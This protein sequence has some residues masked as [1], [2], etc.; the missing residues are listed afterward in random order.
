MF[1]VYF[2]MPL[3]IKEGVFSFPTV[4]LEEGASTI[5]TAILEEDASPTKDLELVG[6]VVL[7]SDVGFSTLLRKTKEKMVRVALDSSFASLQEDSVNWWC[8]K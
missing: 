2:G 1:K 7:D 6:L 5:P 3:Y 4:I 8:F